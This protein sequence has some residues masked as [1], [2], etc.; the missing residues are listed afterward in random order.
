M[1]PGIY[2]WGVQTLDQKGL[3]NFSVG[4]LFVPPHPLLPVVVAR[5]NSLRPY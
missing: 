5:Y 2:D 1:D 3:L 4:I